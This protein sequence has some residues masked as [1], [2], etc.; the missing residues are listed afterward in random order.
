MRTSK[1]I[2]TGWANNLCWNRAKRLAIRA[3]QLEQGPNSVHAQLEEPEALM[4]HDIREIFSNIEEDEN[5]SLPTADTNNTT[6]GEG[7]EPENNSSNE[8]LNNQD[9]NGDRTG[10]TTAVSKETASG[11]KKL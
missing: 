10:I 3:K 4:R 7:A 6:K 5:A 8:N 2:W 1:S 9:G 11:K